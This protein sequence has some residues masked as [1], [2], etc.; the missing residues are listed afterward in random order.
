MS[1]VIERDTG[2]SSIRVTPG[3]VLERYDMVLLET[4]QASDAQQMKGT[5]DKCVLVRYRSLN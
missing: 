4:V 1:N 2:S 3:S 5:L